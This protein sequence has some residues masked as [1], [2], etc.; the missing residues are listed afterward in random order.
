MNRRAAIT[1]LVALLA[2][3][4][5]GEGPDRETAPGPVEITAERG[6]VRLTV[7]AEN[8]SIAAGDRVALT[9]T[10]EAPESVE[11]EVPV[12]EGAVGPFAVREARTPP[13]ELEDQR[14]RVRHH[15]ELDTFAAGDQEIPPI[16]VRYADRRPETLAREGAA[17]VGELVSAAV[18]V[19]VTSALGDDPAL[20]DIR[21]A[22]EMPF[23]SGWWWWWLVGA[24][25]VIAAVGGW[26]AWSGRRRITERV[27]PVVP[28]DVWALAELSRLEAGDL[29]E[30][31]LF[32]E[33]YFA[34]SGIVRVYI[35]RRFGLRAP[36]RTTEEFLREAR[37]SRALSETH[38]DLL[39]GFLRAAD[40][41]KFAR[42]EP[43]VSESRSAL[44]SA[45]GFV[46][47]TRPAPETDATSRARGA[48]A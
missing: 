7:R 14:Q 5:A 38:K 42:H 36:E 6:E 44:E 3:G 9:V 28:A 17:M 35:E 31:G 27:D 29:V 16:T 46:E 43:S 11:L 25:V 24:L 37:S 10:V 22:V 12:M 13:A 34:L 41:V 21:G 1:T 45:R 15:Y 18:P 2:G 33:F 8:D 19:S 26:V 40:L 47:Q 32:S 4:C 20:R 48:A 23:G 39:A 30:R